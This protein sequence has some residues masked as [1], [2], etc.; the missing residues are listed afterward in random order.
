MPTARTTAE[1]LDDHRRAVVALRNLA[2][3]FETLSDAERA[4]FPRTEEAFMQ[5]LQ[6]MRDE[7]DGEVVLALVASA[8]RCLRLDCDARLGEKNAPAV[9]FKALREQFDGRVPLE[10]VLEYG[11]T[12]RTLARKQGGSSRCTST[13]T[14]SRTGATSTK[15]GL[16]HASPEDVSDVVRELFDAIRTVVADFPRP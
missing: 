14:G 7:L 11:R 3:A 9:R 1:V 10:E 4:R 5:T 2:R 6:G 15:S 13:G 16:H 8:E 12:S